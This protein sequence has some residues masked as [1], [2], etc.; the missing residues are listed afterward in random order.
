MSTSCY[1]FPEIFHS[2]GKPKLLKLFKWFR[3]IFKLDKPCAESKIQ[4]A[5][6]GFPSIPVPQPL[7]GQWLLP[8]P[9]QPPRG[10][11]WI[12]FYIYIFIHVSIAYIHVCI[13]SHNKSWRLFHSSWVT[14][15]FISCIYS[16]VCSLTQLSRSIL[17]NIWVPSELLPSQTMLQWIFLY[18]YHFNRWEYISG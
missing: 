4:K 14:F 1:I 17:K 12:L 6:V 13:F 16:S 18:I 7:S 15:F 9:R 10:I 11:W 3:I 2:V 8:M 5:K